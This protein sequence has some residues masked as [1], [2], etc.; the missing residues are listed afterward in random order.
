MK[1]ICLIIFLISL[2][3]TILSINLLNR[4]NSEIE[5]AAIDGQVVDN[6][7]FI[8][9]YDMEYIEVEKNIYYYNYTLWVSS[10]IL[11]I[12]TGISMIITLYL[13][14][15]RPAADRMFN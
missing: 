14:I 13:G 4:N 6:E 15:F 8:M 11:G 12:I 1:K 2:P 10:I 3:L 7:Y 9:N 5:C